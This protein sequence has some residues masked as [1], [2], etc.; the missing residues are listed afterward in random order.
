MITQFLCRSDVSVAKCGF[1]CFKGVAPRAM[2]LVPAR[3]D[4]DQV[5]DWATEDTLGRS[6]R[7][8][9]VRSVTIYQHGSLELVGIKPVP[10]MCC[11][12]SFAL[13]LNANFC[14]AVTA[15]EGYRGKAV[16]YSPIS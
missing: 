2:R 1:T 16:M 12:L 4:G 5:L 3:Q 9:V 10:C 11:P 6:K 14:P 15:W 7:C 8:R 13:I